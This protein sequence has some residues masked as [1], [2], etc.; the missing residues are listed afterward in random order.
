MRQ[1]FFLFV[2]FVSTSSRGQTISTYSGPLGLGFDDQ[3]I[4]FDRTGNLYVAGGDSYKVY[5]IDTLGGVITIAGL[6]YRGFSGDGGPATAAAVGAVVGIAIDSGG[7]VF[8]SDDENVVRK[9]DC[10]SG[11]ITTVAGNGLT[12]FHGDGVLATAT[13]LYGPGGIC[14]DR[15]NN[16]IISD[17]A[18]ERIRKVGSDGVI[19]TIAGH[20]VFGVQYGDG[21]PATAASLIPNG[22]CIDDWGNIYSVQYNEGVIRKIDTFGIITTVAGDSMQRLYNGDGIAATDAHLDPY[23][24]VCDRYGNLFVSDY[25]NERIKEI[26]TDGIIHTVAGNGIVGFSGDGG[27]ADSAEMHGPAGLALDRCDNLYF[28]DLNA[29]RIRKVSFNPDCW[30]LGTTQPIVSNANI[31]LTPNPA[32]QVLTITSP[33]AMRNIVLTDYLGR[34]VL[35]V[36]CGGQRQELDVSALPPGLYVARMELADGEVVVRKVVKE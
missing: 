34:A 13:S 20:G 29:S 5:K 9:I 25:Y 2:F 17:V 11:V 3:N 14:F 24:L 7:N 32:T 1:L 8:F 21:G 19:S 30:P 6:G 36:A 12:G 4:A 22:I 26:T 27:P 35:R 15:F 18:N 23:T 33:Q 10:H 31:T 16:L 28:M